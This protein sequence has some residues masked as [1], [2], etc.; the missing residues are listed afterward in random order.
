MQNEDLY[1]RLLQL[2]RRKARLIL[3]FSDGDKYLLSDSDLCY[4]TAQD[5]T[6]EH[7]PVRVKFEDCLNESA[8]MIQAYNDGHLNTDGVYWTSDE[9]PEPVMMDYEAEDIIRIWNDDK[10]FSEYEKTSVNNA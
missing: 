9:P 2:L 1:D 5:G 4:S 7:A 6:R 3:E 8:K 10:G